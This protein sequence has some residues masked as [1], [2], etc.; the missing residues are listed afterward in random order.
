[1]SATATPG[2]PAQTGYIAR[3]SALA[4]SFNP[5]VPSDLERDDLEP[6]RIEESGIKRQLGKA[7]AVTFL[8]FLAWAMT[9]PLDAGVVV[10]GTVVVQGSRKAVQHPGGGVVEAILVHEGT[11]VREGDI[12]VRINPLNIEANLR[13]AE[14]EFINVLAQHSRLLA[15]R[16]EQRDI[17]WDPEL[18]RL[19]AEGQVGEAQRLQAALFSSRRQEVLGQLN[20]LTR[21]LEGMKAQLVEKETILRLRQSQLS[22]LRADADNIAKLAKDGFVPRHQASNAERTNMEALAG[23]SSLQAELSATRTAIAANELEQIKLKAAFTKTVDAELSEAQKTREVL[24]ARV[25]SLRFDKNLTSIRAPVGGTVVGLK[26]HTVGGVITSGQVLMEIVP[27]EQRLIAEVAVPPRLIDKVAVGLPTDMRFTAF[28]QQST[29]V[30]PGVVRLV[31]A[32]RQ[33][34]QPPLFPEEYFLCQVEVTAE[35]LSLLRDHNVVPGMP[36]DVVIKTGERSFMSYLLKPLSDRVARS[37]K[38]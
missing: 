18:A 2:A 30:I 27:A 34:P 4:R 10:S 5:Y 7:V 38:E 24:R 13:Q 9:A 19:G 1:M 29:P 20:I 33:P 17:R 28:N 23:L 36:V 11:K 8:L 25:E 26:A 31:G 21:Q 12:L 22:N 16:F 3:L 32:D 14:S 37:F 35:G 6:L 15:E